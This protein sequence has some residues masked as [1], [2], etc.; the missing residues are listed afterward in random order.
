[1]KNKQLFLLAVLS[2]VSMPVVRAAE[3]ASA[4]S[5]ASIGNSGDRLKQLY[6]L[7]QE[8]SARLEGQVCELSAKLRELGDAHA[9]L[10]SEKGELMEQYL[11]NSLSH[12]TVLNAADAEVI[13]MQD[14]YRAMQRV[15]VQL[16]GKHTGLETQL[17]RMQGLSGR[18]V[19]LQE[20]CRNLKVAGEAK[21]AAAE[22]LR[23]RFEQLVSTDSFELTGKIQTVGE[24]LTQLEEQ[25]R[26]KEQELQ[27]LERLTPGSGWSALPSRLVT[28][29]A[30]EMGVALPLA[31]TATAVA[32]VQGVQA[33]R[34]RSQREQDQTRLRLE[35]AAL[36]ERIAD[37]QATKS[38]LEGQ[39][40]MVAQTKELL[41]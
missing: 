17:E 32:V 36:Q 31:A 8:K 21:K 41:K 7:E 12:E 22:L 13:A 33:H 24:E 2:L 4:S 18:I 9:Q 40:E 20:M 25:K 39:S 23:Q 30:H 5:V 3:G 11:D 38:A 16:Q 27:V 15:L 14:G 1:M 26:A 10:E 6:Q 28:G 34:A 19:A 37:K 35:I 29:F